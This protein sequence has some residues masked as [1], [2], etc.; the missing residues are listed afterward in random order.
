M[1]GDQQEANVTVTVD[2]H[3]PEWRP[4]GLVSVGPGSGSGLTT[5]STGIDLET[6]RHGRQKE[7]PSRSLPHAQWFNPSLLPEHSPR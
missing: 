6:A 7:P 4:R 3:R 5:C 2:E 1:P